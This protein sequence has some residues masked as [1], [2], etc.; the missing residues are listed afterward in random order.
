MTPA[1]LSISGTLIQ[2]GFVSTPG[3]GSLSDTG[4]DVGM[5]SYT[6]DRSAVGTGESSGI[7]AERLSFSLTSGLTAADVAALELHVCDASVVFS[8]ATYTSTASTHIDTDHSYTWDDT[9]LDWSS[10]TTR[11]LYLSVPAASTV[12]TPTPGGPPEVAVPSDWSLIPAGLGPG[13]KFRLLFLS[14]TKR[15]AS[16]SSISTYNLFIQGRAAAGH[17]DIQEYSDQFRVIGCTDTLNATDNTNTRSSD[18]DAP[19][20]WLLG[21]NKVANNYEDF[22]DGSW[23]NEGNRQERVGHDR[24]QYLPAVQLPLD[25]LRSPRRRGVQLGECLE[26]SRHCR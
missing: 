26:S 20:Y 2:H 6:I 13:D 10:V 23:D 22:Y 14:S 16:S 15:N 25:R 19:I 11:T 21:G 7:P 5:N 18:T 4:F 8:D 3:L 1:E 12:P 24:P 9:G 17:A